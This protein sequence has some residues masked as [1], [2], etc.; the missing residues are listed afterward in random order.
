LR[1][2]LY[3]KA[4][5]RYYSRNGSY[6]ELREMIDWADAAAPND[7]FTVSLTLKGDTYD[8]QR[9]LLD[10]VNSAELSKLPDLEEYGLAVDELRIDGDDDKYW[11]H[12]EGFL[13]GGRM[14]RSNK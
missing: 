14:T 3:S 2:L 9:Y 5:V 1:Q 13:T 11:Y 4:V 7:S 8:W 10:Y 12:P 6:K